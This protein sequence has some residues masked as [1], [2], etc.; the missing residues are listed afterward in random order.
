M[1]RRAEPAA[2]DASVPILVVPKLAPTEAPRRWAALLRQIFEV[3]PLACPRCAGP[4]R[5]V[6]CITQSP[7]VG[8]VRCAKRSQFGPESRATTRGGAWPRKS[9]TLFQPHRISSGVR[10]HRLHSTRASDSSLAP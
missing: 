3:D 9:H 6:A 2:A 8:A 7:L 10:E 1:R 5:I 4:M